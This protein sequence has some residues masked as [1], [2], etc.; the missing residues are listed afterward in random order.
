MSAPGKLI[1]LRD[2][3]RAKIMTVDLFTVLTI[4]AFASAIAGGLLLVSWLQITNLRALGL[5][6]IS[7]TGNGIGVAL[8][9]AR[10]SIPDIWLILIAGAVLAASHGVMWTGVRS[11]ESRSKSVPLMLAGALIW[12]VALPVRGILRL[13]GGESCVDIRDR[14]RIFG[15][16]RSGILARS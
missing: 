2:V 1:F 14:R 10:G 4:A 6:A 9:A 7:F 11:F 15:P 13:A 3:H 5:W 8:I 16:E 12:L